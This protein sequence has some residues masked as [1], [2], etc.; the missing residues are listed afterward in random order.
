ME[1]IP[2]R[3]T[4]PDIRNLLIMDLIDSGADALTPSEYAERTAHN[5]DCLI[6]LENIMPAAG[7]ERTAAQSWSEALIPVLVRNR[8]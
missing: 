3:Y 2:L 7:A 4:Y 1:R 8:R 6:D 5:L